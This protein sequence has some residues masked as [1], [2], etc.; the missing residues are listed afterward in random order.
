MG[1]YSGI[2]FYDEPAIHERYTTA[3]AAL[4]EPNG[5][6]EEPFVL[7]FLDPVQ[8]CDILDLGCGDAAIG[9]RLLAAG[10]GSYTAVDGRDF[11]FAAACLKHLG[12]ER[13]R[14]MTN[15]P[16]KVEAM[17]DH[18]IEVVDRVPLCGFLT[19]QN[20]VYLETKDQA[21]GHLGVALGSPVDPLAAVPSYPAAATPRHDQ[22]RL[23]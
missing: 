17:A 5:A 1:T 16:L 18:G 12:M 22:T 19:P 20:R 4:D 9:P 8:G 10:A 7:E 3:R 11:G 21:M 14:L 6:L 2:A 15:N 23:R 13:I